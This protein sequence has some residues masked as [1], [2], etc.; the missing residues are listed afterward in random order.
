MRVKNE[1][2]EQLNKIGFSD[3]ESKVYL[4]LLEEGLSPA[5]AIIKKTSLHRNIVYETLDKLRVKRFIS[6][7]DQR[8][9]R[10]FKVLDLEKIVKD[11]ES[12]LSLAKT[13]VDS[14]TVLKKA[15]NVEI[16]TYEGQIGFQ[17]ALLNAIEYIKEGHSNLI[18]G[19]GGD[20]FYSAMGN[21]LKKYEKV[22]IQKDV[23]SK[24]IGNDIQRSDFLEG[25]TIKRK[26]IEIKYLPENFSTPMGTVIFDDKV[27]LQIYS[28]PPA[29]V[30]IKS[31]EVAN[32]YRNYFGMLWRMARK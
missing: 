4:A 30:E 5:G 16:Q 24:V 28:N 26:M 17:T 25:K 8:G 20:N 13:L 11:K 18:M 22:R 12:Q 6:E 21:Q 9:V 32:S 2:L 15:E 27:L 31:K 19:A 29:V 10:H 7:S 3:H 1:L 23:T 14:L